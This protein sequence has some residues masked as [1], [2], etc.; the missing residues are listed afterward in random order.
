MAR[1]RM[2]LQG[3]SASVYD[4]IYRGMIDRGT[5]RLEHLEAVMARVGDGS[6]AGGPAAGMV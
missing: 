5:V 4:L 3:D 6:F 1:L 2:A